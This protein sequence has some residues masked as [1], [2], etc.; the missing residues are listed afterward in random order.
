M[1]KLQYVSERRQSEIRHDKVFSCSISTNIVAGCKN[2]NLAWIILNILGSLWSI[3]AL[4]ITA[5]ATIMLQT[6]RGW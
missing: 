1:E 5:V 2:W 3:A 6:F 4:W